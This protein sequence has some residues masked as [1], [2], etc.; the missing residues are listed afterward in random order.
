M[1]QPRGRLTDDASPEEV[2]RHY[3]HRLNRRSW[4]WPLLGPS[5]HQFADALFWLDELPPWWHLSDLEN[6]LRFLWYFRTG[7]MLGESR[8]WGDL[9][10]LGRRLFPRW[11]GFH[12]SRCQPVRR[13]IVICRAGRI[14]TSRCIDEMERLIDLE[15]HAPPDQ[16]RE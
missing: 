8:E 3:A 2:L 15:Q 10:E 1:E 13:H 14:A 9:W 7:L 12:P 5:Y 4:R 11:V 16:P 6:A